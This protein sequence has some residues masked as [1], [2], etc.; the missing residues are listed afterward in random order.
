MSLEKTMPRY[1]WN[2]SPSR[3]PPVNRGVNRGASVLLHLGPV[4]N[5]VGFTRVLTPVL[6]IDAATRFPDQELT[7]SCSILKLA[8]INPH[9]RTVSSVIT[10]NI[11]Q[12]Y[13]DEPDDSAGGPA[14]PQGPAG[15]QGGIAV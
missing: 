15:G 2:N 5:C 3:M 8:S 13:E 14:G 7:L 1:V 6:E 4:Y 10:M 11:S 9:L 12:T